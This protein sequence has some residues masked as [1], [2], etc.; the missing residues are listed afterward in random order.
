MV[1]G[2]YAD[3]PAATAYDVVVVGAGLGGLSAAAFLARTGR[4]VLVIEREEEP[5][6]Y[7]RSFRRG[8]YLFELAIHIIGQGEGLLLGKL[9]DYLG[10]A[11]RCRFVR[12]ADVCALNFPGFRLSVPA[13]REAYISAHAEALAPSEADGL[14]RCF[15]LSQ[16]VHREVHQLPPVLSLR[17]LEGAVTRFPTLFRYHSS[18]LGDLLD[19]CLV[20]ERLKAVVAGMWP[21]FGLP[22]SQ[23][24]FFT[25]C[26]PFL[27]LVQDGS[28][29]CLGGSQ[30]L[31]DAL[32]AAVESQGGEVI[33]GA[34]VEQIVVR[35]GEARG[36]RLASGREVRAPVVV[37]GCDA[38]ATLERLVGQEHLPGGYL[39]RVRRM[40]ASLSGCVLYAA[41]TMDLAGLEVSSQEFLH[42]DWDSD[43]AF[44]EIRSGRPAAA[45]MNVPTLVDP[46]L[47]PAG[48]HIVVLTT[49]APADTGTPWE[50]EAGRYR[51]AL[52]ALLER[53]IPGIGAQLTHAE[54]A[55]PPLFE[56]YSGN[57]GGALYGW[58]SSP[59]QA[60]GRRLSRVT[61]VRGLLLSGHWTQ[62]GM[63]SFRVLFSGVETTM[64]VAGQGYAEEF[65][66]RM[67][68]VPA[69]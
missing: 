52:L 29:Q 2:S 11:D 53:R 55:T 8:D 57:W 42:D 61:P 47:A 46:S 24:S 40:R 37:S 14:R 5:G 22:P 56:R 9:L 67:G 1:E 33:C 28:W 26:T 59:D 4:S 3:E 21:F 35:D 17:E 51:D 10:V 65:L 31:A 68:L 50:D 66:H 25:W 58:E 15:E 44:T 12:A 34:P 38:R 69:R 36:V 16:Q 18:T 54:V 39:R 20:D 6:G 7:A 30:S 19:E 27:S 64:V 48:H 63:G 13:G 32:V 41:T 45:W 43:S 60:G 49:L 62:P 23:L